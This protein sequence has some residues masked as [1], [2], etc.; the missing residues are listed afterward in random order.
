MGTFARKQ[1]QSQKQ[2]S[3]GSARANIATST[4][5][6]RNHPI[7]HSLR[8][9][10]NQALQPI[11]R[12]NAEAPEAGLICTA[13]PRFAHDFSRIPI[14]SPTTE[15]IQ[16]K[17][18]VN[19]S[20]DE[21][22]QE[23]DR[24]A[25]KVV[26]SPKA[27]PPV[28]AISSSAS[29]YT[30]PSIQPY[31]IEGIRSGNLRP[32]SVENEKT[33]GHTLSETTTDLIQRKPDDAAKPQ[34]QSPAKMEDKKAELEFHS[35]MGFPDL[36]SFTPDDLRGHTFRIYPEEDRFFVIGW[37]VWNTG[38][39]MAPS[40]HN[41]LTIYDAHDCAGCRRPEDL[42]YSQDSLAFDTNSIT[43]PGKHEYEESFSID[44]LPAGHYEA[45]GEL[46]VNNEVD[47]INE[48]NNTQFM[49]FDVK[50]LNKPKSN[51]D[52]GE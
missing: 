3:S 44:G 1:N 14:H 13:S 7:L 9:L 51:T 20:G 31:G 32:Q 45:F 38:W 29:V 50:P 10:G 27:V 15:V 52:V 5:G 34:P 39:K 42:V 41:R 6:H 28:N 36:L 49:I 25:E 23:A 21:Y 37:R 4:L 35:A 33:D 47:E 18:A 17:L 48:D 12:T 2:V 8:A 46:D 11:L 16:T 43:Q 40:H 30:S 24:I 22:E 19:Q 26:N